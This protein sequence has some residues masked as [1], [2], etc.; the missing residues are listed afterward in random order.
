MSK[1]IHC[2]FVDYVLDL[3][4]AVVNRRLDYKSYRI[5]N[6]ETQE[7]LAGKPPS[8]TSSFQNYDKQ[9]LIERH[10]SRFQSNSHA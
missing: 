3:M 5:A 6:D 7:R 2:N 4:A 8:L 9:A 1:T 10:R